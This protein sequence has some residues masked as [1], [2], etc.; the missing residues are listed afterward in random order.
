MNKSILGAS[1]AI[2]CL[3]GCATMPDVQSSYGGAAYAD[4]AAEEEQASLSDEVELAPPLPSFSSADDCARAYPGGSGC[5][6]ADA[7]FSDAGVPPPPN[8]AAWFIPYAFAAMTNVLLQDYFSVPAPYIVGVRYEAFTSAAVINNYMHISRSAI[9]A[10]NRAPLH[11]RAEI[12]RSGPLRYSPSRGTVIGPARFATATSRRTSSSSRSSSGVV[13][14]RPIVRPLE[15]P[16]PAYPSAANSASSAAKRSV[17]ST[18]PAARPTA[19]SRPPAAAYHA[20]IHT[21]PTTYASAPR[22]NATASVPRGSSCVR[23]P[24]HSC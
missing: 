23:R 2:L 5:A 20:P 22:Q 12:G 16:A 3:A 8:A 17:S 4:P 7:V 10:Y 21:A 15:R 24:G 1:V 18:Y 9:D 6:S 14:A 11:I 19:P 13:S